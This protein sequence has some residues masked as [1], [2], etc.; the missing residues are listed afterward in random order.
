MCRTAVDVLGPDYVPFSGLLGGVIRCV[1]VC[2]CMHACMHTHMYTRLHIYICTYMYL[3]C[4][5]VCMYGWM[6]GWMDGWMHG[7]M[8]F[9]WLISAHCC[10]HGVSRASGAP[11]CLQDEPAACSDASSS[12]ILG[13]ARL[14]ATK[15]P[16]TLHRLPHARDQ[17]HYRYTFR[18]PHHPPCKSAGPQTGLL[19][20]I[21]EIAENP[22]QFYNGTGHYSRPDDQTRSQDI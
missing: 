20:K 2:V 19:H 21:L 1:R 6:D 7:M 22:Y 9:I 12:K 17:L 18:I 8:T 4:L 3:C 11:P 16:P 15:R 10:C 13:R 5:Y 14:S